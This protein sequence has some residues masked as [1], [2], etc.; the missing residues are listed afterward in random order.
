VSVS[1]RPI[2]PSDAPFLFELYSGT[3][4][5]ELAQVDWTTE[6]KHAFLR[7]QFDA[8]QRAYADTYGEADF[9]V[10][11]CDG[12]PGGR[13]YLARW[14]A[15]IRI[16]DIVLLADHRG[17][18]I[19]SGLIREVQDEAAAAGRAVS[20]HVERFNPAKRLYER[21]GFRLAAER[22]AVYLLMRWE[23]EA[24]VEPSRPTPPGD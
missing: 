2:E 18:G 10:I 7:H 16:V 1:L 12:V 23:P 19:G 14:P 17:R 6:Q 5:A 20:I 22:D 13:L 9:F 11:L 15:E 4:E 8:Q 21:L 24:L 3:R